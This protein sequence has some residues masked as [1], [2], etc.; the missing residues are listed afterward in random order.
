MKKNILLIIILLI[1]SVALFFYLQKN[2]L[3]EEKNKPIEKTSPTKVIPEKK[4]PLK[5]EIKEVKPVETKKVEKIKKVEEIK[6]NLDPEL[7]I[8]KTQRYKEEKYQQPLSIQE[9]KDAKEKDLDISFG[10]DVDK[11]EK[12]LDGFSLGVEKK[13]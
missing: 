2:T 9:A 12:Q 6:L 7:T 11:K 5:K 1:A 13:F 10:V 4:A 8:D 3:N